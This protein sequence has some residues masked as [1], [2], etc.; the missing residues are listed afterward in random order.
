METAKNVKGAIIFFIKFELFTHLGLCDDIGICRDMVNGDTLAESKV[1]HG[2]TFLVCPKSASYSSF[3]DQNTRRVSTRKV[4]WLLNFNRQTNIY[5]QFSWW[6]LIIVVIEGI[7]I[8]GFC[9]SV[10]SCLHS[11]KLVLADWVFGHL[12]RL[13]QQLTLKWQG[14]QIQKYW[15]V[16]SHYFPC[17]HVNFRSKSHPCSLFV[18][19][20]WLQVVY[21]SIKYNP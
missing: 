6:L 19:D 15:Y 20:L 3:A 4:R 13:T 10:T 7:L 8:I 14:K 9:K 5:V 11:N 17:Y 18:W 16:L 2:V 21:L 12:E 1:E